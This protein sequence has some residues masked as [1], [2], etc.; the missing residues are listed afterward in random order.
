MPV[1]SD[2]ISDCR[3]RELEWAFRLIANRR[4]W[5]YSILYLG[6]TLQH[7]A[8]HSYTICPFIA[9]TSLNQMLRWSNRDRVLFRAIHAFLLRIRYHDQRWSCGSCLPCSRLFC[10]SSTAR[11]YP[12]ITI[13]KSDR[14]YYRCKRWRNICIVFYHPVDPELLRVLWRKTRIICS[15]ASCGPIIHRSFSLAT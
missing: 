12:A 5:M 15:W 9:D 10:C 1:S 8:D 7:L 3:F 13:R 14:S 2:F 11:D 6:P 4:C